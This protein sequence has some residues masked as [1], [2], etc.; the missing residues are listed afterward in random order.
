MCCATNKAKRSTEF[1]NQRVFFLLRLFCDC[2]LGFLSDFVCALS[3]IDFVILFERLELLFQQPRRHT[4]QTESTKGGPVHVIA[5]SGGILSRFQQ[6]IGS[7]RILTAGGALLVILI[8]ISSAHGMR[9][10]GT[11]NSQS[12]WVFLAKFCYEKGTI[13]LPIVTDLAKGFRRRRFKDNV[14][15]PLN[16][17]FFH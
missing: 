13:N 9:V 12:R 6:I 8:L 5:F 3:G 4:R 7:M 17:K 15:L 1:L 16:R 10:K 14:N 2:L 11:L